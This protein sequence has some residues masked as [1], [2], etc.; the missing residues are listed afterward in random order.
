MHVWEIAKES[1]FLGYGESG[2]F[3]RDDLGLAGFL[4]GAQRAAGEENSGWRSSWFSLRMGREG[5]GQ[6]LEDWG[7]ARCWS[8]GVFLKVKGEDLL[9]IS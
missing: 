8:L 9:E 7:I 2:G 5:E 4:R 3:Y 1:I 6:D